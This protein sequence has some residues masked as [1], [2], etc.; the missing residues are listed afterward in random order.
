MGIIGGMMQP[1]WQPLIGRFLARPTDWAELFGRTAPLLCEIGMGRGDFIVLLAQQ[2]PT[3]NIIGCELSQPSLARVSRKLKSHQLHYVRPIDGSGVDLL[4]FNIA[5]A[6]LDALYINFPDPW[7]KED[8]HQ[9]RL[10]NERFLHLCATR[11]KEGAELSIATDHPDYQPVVTACLEATPYFS[12]QL[13]T[14]YSADPRYRRQ[15]KYEEKAVREGRESHYYLWRR[16]AT[17]AP[18]LFPLPV[19]YAM[20]HVHLTL[21]LT[22]L[23]IAEQFTPFQEALSAELRASFLACYY[24]PQQNSLLIET[25]IY[26]YPETQRVGLLVTPRGEQDGYLVKLHEI[27]YPRV[28]LA[29]HYAISRLAHWLTTLHPSAELTHHNLQPEALTSENRPNPPH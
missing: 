8:H 9:R 4:W 17:P 24:S 26:Q 7:Y 21:P 28:T 20:P 25:Y 6:T 13:A 22:A 5:P 14:S 11:L 1:F 27:G 19:E 16:N 12:S 15:T 23:Q 29:L 18:D 3:S 2:H 10:I